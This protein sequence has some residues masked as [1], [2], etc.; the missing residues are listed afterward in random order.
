MPPTKE[1][2]LADVLAL[3]KEDREAHREEMAT[4]VAQITEP[5]R[6]KDEEERQKL[7][8]RA[9][10][11]KKEARIEEEARTSAQRVCAHKKR[12]GSP[13]WGGQVNTDGYVRPM[14]TQCFKIMPE[15]KAPVEWIQNGVNLQNKE[16]FPSLTEADIL[17]W[18]KAY[19]PKPKIDPRA[20]LQTDV[21]ATKGVEVPA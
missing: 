9:E 13:S 20:N 8:R 19:G 15:I 7:L 16:I 10:N 11:A 6:R 3:L 5:Q 17:A 18:H 12:D 21:S 2:T 1:I 4:L 14:C